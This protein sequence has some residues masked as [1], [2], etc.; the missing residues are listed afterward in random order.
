M[1]FCNFSMQA[2]LTIE[3]CKLP[4]SLF[5]VRIPYVPIESRFNAVGVLRQNKLKKKKKKL[6]ND[7]NH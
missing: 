7:Y 2:K 1:Q 5:L 4:K 6:E 3:N